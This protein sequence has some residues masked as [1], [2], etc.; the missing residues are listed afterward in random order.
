[1]LR[2][3]F[4]V[5]PGELEQLG[6]EPAVGVLRDMLWAETANIGIPV[7]QID[8]PYSITTPDGGVDAIV[9][10]TPKTA[11]NGLIFP[12]R[13]TYQVKAG[14]FPLS[15][16]TAAQIE[17]LIVVPSAIKRRVE[18]KAAIN[19]H[20]YQASDISPRI[21]SCLDVGGTF[22]TLLFGNDNIDMI[23]DATEEA[24]RT[25]LGEIDAK[26]AA[27]D[28]KVWRQSRI[29]LL[30]R[31]FPA[32][33]MR[34]RQIPGLRLLRHD[35]WGLQPN[36]RGPFQAAPEQTA[37]IETLR[38]AIR[39]EQ[40]HVSHVRIIGEPGIGKT[41]LVLEAFNT[42]DLRSAVL[43]AERPSDLDGSAISALQQQK[44]AR[45][46]LVV[47]ECDPEQRTQLSRQFDHLGP[48]FKIVSVYQEEQ[49][50][51]RSS[52]YRLFGVPPLPIDKIEAIIASYSVDPA[53]AK[54]WAELCDGSPRV[55]HVVGANLRDHPENPLQDD[56]RSMIWERYLAS[57]VARNSTEY[58]KRQ[59]V[60]S[61]AALFK[62]FG[63]GPKVR[64]LGFE[65]YDKIISKLDATISKDEFVGI[66]QH[67]AAKKVFQGDHFLYITPRA[68]H[69]RL[70][71]D[72]WTRHGATLDINAVVPELSEQMRQWFGEMIE[73]ADATPTAKELVAKWLGPEGLY[74]DA[75]WLRTREGGRFFFSLSLADPSGAVRALERL[76]GKM[77]RE[78]LLA[79]G[80]GRRDIVWTLE[81]TA[82]HSALFL[83][84]AKLLLRL[85]D[86]ETETWTN[87]ATGV[88][89]GL[90]SL[91][92]GEVAPTALAPEHRLPLLLDCLARGDRATEIALSAFDVALNFQHTS[93]IGGDQPF[94][95][96]ERV[97]RWLP[98]TYGELYAAIRL[99]WDALRTFARGSTG[100]WRKRAIHILL[101]HS[102]D[103]LHVG[104]LPPDVLDT[105]DE[106]SNF[107]DADM[108]EVISAIELILTYDAASLNAEVAQRLDQLRNKAVGATFE[109][110]MQRY[111]G[112]D[113]LRDHYDT[114]GKEID[115]AADVLRG[116]AE[117]ALKE[118]EK[119][120]EALKWL[121]T[122]EAK[123]GYRFGYALGRIDKNKS[124]W[125][126]IRRAWIAAG[127][128]AHD[129]FIGGYLHDW[130]ECDPKGWELTI[131]DLAAADHNIA[132]LPG[133]VW[134]S[135]LTDR[136]AALL[137]ELA[138]RKKIPPP[139]FG[140]FA[141]GRASA[142]LSDERFAEWLEFLMGQGTYEAAATALNL[143]SMSLMGDRILT[144]DQLRKLL[145]QP[146][147]FSYEDR[148]G[149]VMLSHYW[150]QLA[151]AL[152]R[153]DQ[154]SEHVVLQTLLENIGNSDAVT[155][156]MGPDG[157]RYLDEL[158]SRHPEETWETVSK[159]L[160][161]P[162]DNR[163]FAVRRWLQG[164]FS[165]HGRSPGPIRHIS[166]DTIEKWIR[167]DP[168]KR[169][170]FV[171]NM[172]P[173]DFTP[174][175]WPRS[176]VR[177]VLCNYGDNDAVQSAVHANFFTG[178]WSGPASSHYATM[179]DQL[180]QLKKDEQNPHAQRWLGDSI[181][182]TEHY[183]ESAK[184][185]EEARGY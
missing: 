61:S 67:M 69:I 183:L 148:Q 19:G 95:L 12:P 38:A 100:K 103:I 124:L 141:M 97:Q 65:L 33:V 99:Y 75:D 32:I 8:V 90:F 118:P 181:K 135:G 133:L 81:G 45:V 9:N 149:D 161:P 112:M 80:E 25:F 60:L 34:I 138:K 50:G 70:W 47:D 180:L 42:D 171:A 64:G 159:Y 146:A 119:F 114:E 132:D 76:I 144:S 177:D 26:Y 164:D 77:D 166:R 145:T 168:N 104:D 170:A 53:L 72:W 182:A 31:H 129:H 1:M 18:A 85:A 39:D 113:L 58:R 158:V 111:V 86:A 20:F 74:K 29:C 83:P 3:L 134:R 127:S 167:G 185:E 106:I 13:T 57:D 115:K 139:R 56:G 174:D 40:N 117:E 37:A 152:V 55:A 62:R 93:R 5:T 49:E 92:Y 163:G 122:A 63:W 4:D 110:R 153:Q 125:S 150:L 36:M 136:I 155:S 24:I 128:A 79:F 73:Y 46:I 175:T 131:E 89:C 160:N 130:F 30:L 109:S 82:L 54:P 121:V 87:N 98:K 22:V 179:Q 108:R 165:F 137:L 176:L 173:K 169:A 78:A 101:S 107:P 6:P 7:T 51:D 120:N 15:A 178:A 105:L 48:A 172:A 140:I 154:Q 35:Q 94:R 157:E 102:R 2:T 16:T 21:R 27:A 142:P 66:I 88:F 184:I 96:N 59:L 126:A 156:N 91:G 10:A 162:I 14:D 41:R 143:A 68:F 52:N 123:N 71:I 151:K 23:E 84:S 116:L 17:A 11:G 44:G 147:L 28:V 43:Y